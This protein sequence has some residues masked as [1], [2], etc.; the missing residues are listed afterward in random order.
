MNHKNDES[1]VAPRP[2]P[3]IVPR[4][5]MGALQDALAYLDEHGYVVISDVASS[6][7]IEIG[8]DLAWRF[9]EGLQTQTL[10]RTLT[11]NSNRKH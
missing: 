4:F 1:Y 9:I 5:P 7:E 8:R 10:N 11:F 2:T 6:E 3:T